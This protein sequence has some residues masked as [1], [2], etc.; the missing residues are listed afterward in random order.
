MDSLLFLIIAIPAASAAILLLGGKYTDAWGHWLGVVAPIASFVL[1]VAAFIDLK[2]SSEEALHQHLY[3]WIH[4]G[5]LQR[6]DGVAVR[7]PDGAVRAAHH[8]CRAA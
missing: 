7:S 2:G 4:V 3:D 1:G 5:T 6:R 8:R